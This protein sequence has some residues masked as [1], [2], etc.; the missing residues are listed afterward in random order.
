MKRS[1]LLVVSKIIVM[2]LA[3]MMS[4]QLVA[5]EDISTLSN[6]IINSSYSSN[7]IRGQLRPIYYT[8]ISAGMSAKLLSF[9]V[10]VGERIETGQRIAGF[11]C[12]IQKAN[13]AIGSGRLDGT[14]QKLLVNQRLQELG[15][16]SALE[17]SLA[18]AEMVIA[19]A[20]LQ[21]EKILMAECGVLA[22]FSGTVTEKY[23]RA[24][25]FVNRGEPL[26]ELIDTANL[27]VEMI[28]PSTFLQTFRPGEPF[29]MHID[30][31]GQVIAAKLVRITGV[32]D[33]V[34]Q[35]VKLI[36]ELLDSPENLLPGMSGTITFPRRIAP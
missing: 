17:L 2:H 14:R 10:L 4:M 28:V 34:S 31:T 32:V 13:V 27:E 20:E 30:E 12:E 35:T 18:E 26:F 6:E 24:F 16:A 5:A 29:D 25:Q 7:S 23:A 1:K 3:T 21:R 9:P 15:D 19:E 36:G 22:P 33:P 11:D 8:I